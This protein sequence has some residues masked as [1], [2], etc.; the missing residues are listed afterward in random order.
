V[1]GIPLVQLSA[2]PCITLCNLREPVGIIVLHALF[3]LGE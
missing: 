2:Q 3:A 1:A